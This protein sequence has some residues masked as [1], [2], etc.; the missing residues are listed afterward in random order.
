MGVFAENGA[1]GGARRACVFLDVGRGARDLSCERC[2]AK[3]NSVNPFSSREAKRP[4]S[5]SREAK[6]ST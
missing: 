1:R 4:F 5:S 3:P 2:E 6:P